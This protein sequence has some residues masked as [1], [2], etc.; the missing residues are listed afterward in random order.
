MEIEDGISK[1]MEKINEKI[2]QLQEILKDFPAD[3]NT[4]ILLS[5]LRDILAPA[6]ASLMIANDEQ[7]Q[8]VCKQIKL[9]TDISSAVIELLDI[10]K[11]E[12][13]N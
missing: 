3:V 9:I 6:H 2:Q 11:V 12:I 13:K 7:S 1:I 5:A 4:Y 8:I 10:K